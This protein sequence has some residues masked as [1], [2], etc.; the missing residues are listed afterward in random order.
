M[1][2][3]RHDGRSRSRITLR[4][5]TTWP[6]PLTPWSWNT[7]LAISTPRVSFVIL[8]LL[9]FRV[10]ALSPRAEGRAVHPVTQW[11]IS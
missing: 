10:P 6:L 8:A 7:F 3:L 1:W 2:D 4:F 9:C 5:K 11:S